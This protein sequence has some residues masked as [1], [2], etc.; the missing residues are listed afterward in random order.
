MAKEYAPQ[1]YVRIFKRLSVVS[2][3]LSPNLG[4][5]TKEV[6]IWNQALGDTENQLQKFGINK[7][8]LDNTLGDNFY[9]QTTATPD[10]DKEGHEYN[11]VNIFN[12]TTSK[13]IYAPTGTWSIEFDYRDGMIG[14]NSIFLQIEP[15]DYVEIFMRREPG[16]PISDKDYIRTADGAIAPFGIYKR[17]DK[18]ESKAKQGNV[19]KTDKIPTTS[20]TIPGGLDENGRYYVNLEYVGN[21]T[22]D[23]PLTVDQKTDNPDLIMCGFVDSITNRFEVQES[24]TNNRIIVSGRCVGKILVEHHLYYNIQAV[25]NLTANA[26]GTMSIPTLTP[27]GAIDFILTKYLQDALDVDA[28]LEREKFAAQDPSKITVDTKNARNSTYYTN[29]DKAIIKFN[30]NGVGS[31]ITT[32]QHLAPPTA[33]FI[34]WAQDIEQVWGRLEDHSTEIVKAVGNVTEGPLWSKLQQMCN[35]PLYELWVDE[36]GNVVCRLARDAWYSPK[37]RKIKPENVYKQIVKTEKKSKEIGPLYKVNVAL[38]PD[39]GS[40]SVI[41]V[42]SK[43]VYTEFNFNQT[44]ASSLET[45][46][47]NAGANV[48]IVRTSDSTTDKQIIDS[49]ASGG[50]FITISVNDFTNVTDIT[51]IKSTSGYFTLNPTTSN[52]KNSSFASVIHSKLTN[53]LQKFLNNDGSGLKN[54]GTYSATQNAIKQYRGSRTSLEH[55]VSEKAYAIIVRPAN[56]SNVADD[57]MFILDG[58]YNEEWINAVAQGLFD[59]LKQMELNKG[60]KEKSKATVY[61]PTVES[62]KKTVNRYKGGDHILVELKDVHNWNL[63]RSDDELKTVVMVLPS[64]YM[65]GTYSLT[66]GLFGQVPMTQGMF[67]YVS[68]L[69]EGQIKRTQDEIKLLKPGSQTKIKQDE[70]DRLNSKKEKLKSKYQTIRGQLTHIGSFP[71]GTNEED[72]D[73]NISRFWARFGMRPIQVNDIYDSNIEDLIDAALTIFEKN[74]G[75]FFK[76]SITVKGSPRYKLGRTIEIPEI[77]TTFYCHAIEHNFTW[78][79]G[80]TT[81]LNLS[82][83]RVDDTTMDNLLSAGKVSYVSSTLEKS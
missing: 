80:W 1:Y 52:N 11:P 4:V 53:K 10:V 78:G 36:T 75:F 48:T 62:V 44:I 6:A 20:A 55:Q 13:D 7:I 74:A 76:G 49:T 18:D 81:T 23:Q 25:G 56:I 72:Q 22:K 61:E 43:N 29:S 19:K 68:Y 27:V 59:G 34:S 58:S 21:F 14:P 66:A 28:M 33:R 70:I 42:G 17:K 15:M 37:E 77:K 57:D 63:V 3:N 54:R 5:T 64:S 30:P 40:D 67:S 71:L 60:K 82:F 73:L 31:E 32:I 69:L 26:L 38:N 83:G 24:A 12:I 35:S 51:N 45:L 50:Y 46:L 41:P 16:V 47:V 9:K 8:Q 79:E 65:L 2:E 39:I